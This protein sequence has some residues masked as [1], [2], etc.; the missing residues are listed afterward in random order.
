MSWQGRGP[1]GPYVEWGGEEARGAG[2][3]DIS[4][5]QVWGAI[6][7]GAPPSPDWGQVPPGSLSFRDPLVA[8]EWTSGPVSPDCATRKS[9][10][11]PHLQP[12]CCAE[13]ASSLRPPQ[14]QL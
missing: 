8:G 2:R 5:E 11:A 13:A 1:A 7:L 12:S 4:E 10:L 3:G 14:E 9:L 6:L